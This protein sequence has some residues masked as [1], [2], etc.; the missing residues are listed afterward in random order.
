MS[1]KW[2]FREYTYQRRGLD[3][4]RAAIGEARR[5]GDKWLEQMLEREL[6]QMNPDDPLLR[7]SKA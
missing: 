1:Y 5:V 3:D 4:L 2:R 7:T 6:K